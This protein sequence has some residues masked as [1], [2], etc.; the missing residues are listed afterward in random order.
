M[1]L[2]YAMKIPN[3][4][5]MIKRWYNM[6]DLINFRTCYAS[7][8]INRSIINGSIIIC[9]DTGEIYHD[10]LDGER[11]KVA[12]QIVYL[13][14]ETERTSLLTPQINTLYVVKESNIIYRYEDGEWISLSNNDSVTYFYIYNV[15]LNA[16]DTTIISDSRITEDSNAKFI[17]YPSL[18][19]IAEESSITCT[20][21]DKSISVSSD[22]DY[23]L[24]GIIEVSSTGLEIPNAESMSF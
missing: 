21:S 3:T 7:E 19:D 20:C 4:Y 18:Y 11:I 8:L 2:P 1:P 12:E 10:N 17:V 15:E 9:S 22:C 5:Y 13:N 24:Y 16:N 6:P 23:T 14:T